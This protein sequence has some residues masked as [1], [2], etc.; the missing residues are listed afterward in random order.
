MI[1]SQVIDATTHK[2]RLQTRS[3]KAIP[4]QHVLE[5]VRRLQV[6]IAKAWSQGLYRKVKD[7]QRL[8]ATSFYAKLLAVKRVTNN[9]GKKTPGIDRIIWK[10]PTSKMKAAT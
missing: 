5:C 4:W 1:T 3:W 7:L 2:P 6:R 10:S 9:K 8:L